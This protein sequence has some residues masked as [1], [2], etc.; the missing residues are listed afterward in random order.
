MADFRTKNVEED[1][2]DAEE[3][4]RGEPTALDLPEQVV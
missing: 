2:T 4:E 3:L 1:S